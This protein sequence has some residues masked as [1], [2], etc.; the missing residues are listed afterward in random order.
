MINNILKN[1]AIK[2]I[3]F[4]QK[5][6]SPLTPPSC[7]YYPTCSS[8]AL[9]L[10][11]FDNI[12][13]AC[14]KILFRI[15]SCNQFFNG[16]YSP[17]FIFLSQRKIENLKKYNNKKHFLSKP[18][19]QKPQKIIYFFVNADSNLIKLQKFYIIAIHLK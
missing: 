15:L 12:F 3:R 1:L 2:M 4:Y 6:I 11:K 10:F 9:I 14:I 18:M 5:F 19:I 17:P 7:R 16:G 13:C 8:Y